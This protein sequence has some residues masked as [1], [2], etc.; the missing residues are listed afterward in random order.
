M[1]LLDTNIISESVKTPPNAG[2]RNWLSEA[3]PHELY[4]SVLSL[5]E[6]RRGVEKLN[7]GHRKNRLLMWLEHE[8]PQWFG[9]N[10]ISIDKAICER[11]GYLT[12]T[13]SLPPIDSLLA[14]TA[15]VHNLKMVTRNEKDF[16]IEGLEVIN[17]FLYT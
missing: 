7:I 16:K 9:S 14:A 17:P 12:A 10:I 2:V 3:P 1:Y 13:L 11:W 15:L 5:G 8:L 6:V 4:I